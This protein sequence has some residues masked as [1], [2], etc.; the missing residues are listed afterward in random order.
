MPQAIDC[1]SCQAVTFDGVTVRHTSAS[2]IELATLQGPGSAANSG[3]PA[4]GDAITGSTLYDLGDSGIHLGHAPNGGD[5]SA[6]VPTQLLV[7]NNLIQ[8]YGRIAP[9]GEGIATGNGNNFTISHNDV[10]DGYHAGISICAEGCPTWGTPQAPVNGSYIT[11]SFN[12]IANTLQGITNDGG[13]LYYDIGLETKN[14]ANSGYGNKILNNLIHDVT[15][16][17]VIDPPS[18]HG[19]GYGG[20]GIYL[21]ITSA[22]IDIENNVVYRVSD[23]GLNVANFPSDGSPPNTFV[24]NIVAYAR[25]SMF[26][27]QKPWGAGCPAPGQ[28]VPLRAKLASNIFYFDRSEADGL[29]I[30]QGCAYSCGFAYDTMHDFEG[31]LYWRTD[32][33]LAADPD[34]FH[35]QTKAP[36]DP[37]QCSN[38]PQGKEGTQWT[39]LSF[40]QWQSAGPEG[41]AP[42]MSEDEAGTASIDPGF[43]STGTPAD[44]VLAGAPIAGFDPSQTNATITTAGRL[45]PG[46][47][48]APVPPTYPTFAFTAY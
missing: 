12:H 30:Q 1:E 48:L 25:N 21:D 15:D 9:D 32:G 17:Q 10:A 31:N 8:G 33:R 23:A 24:N 7:E 4:S 36:G 19:E 42:A 5:K 44:F 29:F 35:V 26:Q 40:A 2:A 39:G 13:T 37:T 16:S 47:A 18:V 14:G 41:S 22:G 46:P 3:T 20:D 34:A 27:D 45:Q 6:F 38:P 11:T 43:G 28:Q